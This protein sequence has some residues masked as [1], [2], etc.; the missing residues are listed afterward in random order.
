MSAQNNNPVVSPEPSV[1]KKFRSLSVTLSVIFLCLV[2]IILFI[3]GALNLYFNFQREKNLITSNQVRIARDAA[4]AVGEFIAE[5]I[6]VIDQSVYVND[7]IVTS[8]RRELVLNKLIGRVPAFR[9]LLLIDKN[10]K[11]LQKVSRLSNSVSMRLSTTEKSA[12]LSA[13]NAGR[14]YT[15]NVYFDQETQEPII[16]VAASAK[17]VFGDV[18][19]SL[20]AEVNLKFMWDLVGSMKIG[21]NGLAYVVDNKG[22]LIAYGDVSRVLK[23]ENLNNLSEVNEFVK[24]ADKLGDS[25]IEITKGIQNNGYVVSNFVSLGSPNWAVVVEVPVFEA[26]RSLITELIISILIVLGSMFCSILAVTYFSKKITKPIVK[27]TEAAVQIG[28]G[29]FDHEIEINSNDEIGILAKTFNEMTSNLKLKV[30]ELSMEHSRLTASVNSLTL[31]FMIVD[32]QHRILNINLTAQKILGLE[33]SESTIDDLQQ[34]LKGRLDMVSRIIVTLGTRKA[35]ELKETPFSNKFLHI[36]ISPIIDRDKA[37][38]V[39]VLIE[40]ITEAKLIERSRDEFFSIASHEL[41]TPLTAIRGNT[42]LIKQYYWDKLKDKDLREMVGDIHESSTRLIGIVNDFLDTSRL[43]LGKMEF[44]KEKI[45]IG[46][47]ISEV[48][49]EYVTTGSMKKLYLKAEK[50]KVKI[51][52]VVADKDRAKQIIINLIGNAIK[53]TEKGGVTVS[54]EVVGDLVKIL[55]SD[56]GKGISPESQNLLFRKFQQAAESIFTRDAIH[57]TG[58][59]LYISRMMAEGMGGKLKLESS[60]VGKGSVFSMS[61][62]TGGKTATA[63]ESSSK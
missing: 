40:D 16:I 58:L 45:N 59:G 26:Y 28:S 61:L 20:I 12:L 24:D 53:F 35:V 22:N 63:K 32:N 57:G 11:E 2:A 10:G 3:N 9:Q 18:Q 42:A 33:G 39:V 41:R 15:G 27:L 62:P 54:L 5:K 17:D 47:L 29:S 36:F 50:P 56:T 1:K 37:I 55:V 51:P 44:K 13:I 49:K 8:D 48:L 19:G 25:D 6:R 30:S 43:E 14:S 46:D 23:G 34:K 52:L 7:L 31:G 60:I 4:N 21:N 38:G